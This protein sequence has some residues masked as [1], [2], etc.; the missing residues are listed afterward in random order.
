MK[1]LR[2]VN[3]LRSHSYTGWLRKVQ[4]E[5]KECSL[6]LT[7]EGSHDMVSKEPPLWIF[8]N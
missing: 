8:S 1:T 3:N 7:V 5:Q 2:K 6:I 4:K